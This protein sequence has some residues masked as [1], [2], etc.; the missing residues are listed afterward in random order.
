MKRQSTITRR[1]LVGIA[2]AA[3]AAAQEPPQQPSTPEQELDARR[4]RM[5][6]NFEQLSKTPLPMSVEPAVTFRA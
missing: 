5:K 6:A 3:A 1:A 4:A 2:A